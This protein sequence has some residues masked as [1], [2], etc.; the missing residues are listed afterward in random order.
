MGGWIFHRTGEIAPG[1]TAGCGYATRAVSIA[2]RPLG[3]SGREREMGVYEKDPGELRGRR[4][5]TTKGAIFG[6]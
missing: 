3:C 2:T 6:P 4:R 1:L 5:T